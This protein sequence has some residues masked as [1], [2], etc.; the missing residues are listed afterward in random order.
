[1]WTSSGNNKLTVVLFQP[2]KKQKEL[3]W[4]SCRFSFAPGDKTQSTGFCIFIYAQKL[5][6]SGLKMKEFHWNTQK[7]NAFDTVELRRLREFDRLEYVEDGF[8]I[9]FQPLLESVHRIALYRTL[10]HEIGHLYDW[11]TKGAGPYHK[12][13]YEERESFAHDEAT[14]IFS[15]LKEQR[16]IP[17][18]ITQ[19]DEKA[20][21]IKERTI[22]QESIPSEAQVEVESKGKGKVIETLKIEEGLVERETKIIDVVEKSEPEKI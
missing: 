15:I 17:F 22:E 1:V 14:K 19:V 21:L 9:A 4:G 20:Q 18:D 6:E 5:D 3:L 12:R 11:S 8:D 13:G 2:K 10:F 7:L 16:V